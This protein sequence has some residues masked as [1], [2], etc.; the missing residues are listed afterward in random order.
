MAGVV[1]C[2]ANA[3]SEVASAVKGFSPSEEGKAVS[4]AKK[5]GNKAKK[6]VE[7]M[8]PICE[9]DRE[10]NKK[11]APL[12][13]AGVTNRATYRSF[14]ANALNEAYKSAYDEVMA[15]YRQ[16]LTNLANAQETTSPQEQLNNDLAADQSIETK[17]LQTSAGGCLGAMGILTGAIAVLSGFIYG[18]YNLFV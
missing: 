15:L 7:K 2:V 12:K 17:N 16:R 5:A 14:R 11:I 9:T 6:L 4:A 3:V 8:Y 13:L 18:V 10:Y 1:E